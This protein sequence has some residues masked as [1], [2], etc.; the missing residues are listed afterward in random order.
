MTADFEAMI[1]IEREATRVSLSAFLP[2][3]IFQTLSTNRAAVGMSNGYICLPHSRHKSEEQFLITQLYLPPPY[4]QF[5]TAAL[6]N[7]NL[8]IIKAL[9]NKSICRHPK[10]SFHNYKVLVVRS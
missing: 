1:M 3:K 6:A 2:K 10:V 9:G 8:Y 7:D 5:L 4:I